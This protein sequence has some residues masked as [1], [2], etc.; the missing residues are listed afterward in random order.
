MKENKANSILN[1]DIRED[2]TATVS[3]RGNLDDIVLAL[4]NSIG[5][6]ISHLVEG[7][8]ID[9]PKEMFD[10]LKNLVMESI[11]EAVDYESYCEL[12]HY[13]EDDK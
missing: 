4:V 6:T 2:E 3:I 12:E 10:D 8:N 1:V 9:S 11:T 7:A 5:I 13:D